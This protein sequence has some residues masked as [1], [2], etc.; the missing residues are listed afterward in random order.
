M[1][2]LIPFHRQILLALETVYQ[3]Q[4]QVPEVL[5]E[6]WGDGGGVLD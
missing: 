2:R 1:Q 3:E 4:V 6:V 5:G